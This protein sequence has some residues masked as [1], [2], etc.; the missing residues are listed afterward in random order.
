M[1]KGIL[2]A[3]S[4]LL[5]CVIS[6]SIPVNAVRTDN[7]TGRI[8]SIQSERVKLA[9]QLASLEEEQVSSTEE[10]NLINEQIALIDQEFAYQSAI[11]DIYGESVAEMKQK[12]LDTQ[13]EETQKYQRL[14]S[15]LREMEEA[16]TTSF[17]GIIFNVSSIS[18]AVAR[19]EFYNSIIHYE[20]AVLSD[21]TKKRDELGT[22]RYNLRLEESKY[23]EA[24]D[25]LNRQRES[26]ERENRRLQKRIEQ[27]A[28]KSKEVQDLFDA[29]APTITLLDNDSLITHE[30]TNTE[31]NEMLTTAMI[32]LQ[33]A[34]I[35]DDEY[36]ARIKAL[37]EGLG[38]VGRVSYFWGGR[39]YSPGWNSEW[40]KMR[41]IQHAGNSAY[42]L[43]ASFPYGL[44]CSGFVFWCALTAY[45]KN[46]W[47]SPV[48]WMADKGAT[49]MYNNAE[50]VA[51]D[52][53]LPGDIVV[54]SPITHIG[55]YICTNEDGEALFL[56]CSSRYGVVVSKVS[57]FPFVNAAKTF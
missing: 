43:G 13:T 27:L 26:L 19:I 12:L 39:V 7:I 32:E 3:L 57:A 42:P 16:P 9:E 20:K 4:L 2:R 23:A 5:A 45:G 17:W 49:M 22:M 38:L 31:I 35:S 29:Y 18:D 28:L 24:R 48:E 44:D 55:Y 37:R 8:Q 21:I 51:W 34:G 41:T 1:R 46:S 50:K 52:A 33:F 47:E 11:A 40:G 10:L 6:L 25:T 30:L 56:H 14:K 15:V 53:K 54:N 36:E